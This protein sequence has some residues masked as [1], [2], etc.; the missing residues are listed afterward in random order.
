MCLSKFL[1]GLYNYGIISILLQCFQAVSP[2]PLATSLR[3]ENDSRD[4]AQPPMAHQ[5]R[6]ISPSIVI[7]NEP[8]SQELRRSESSPQVIPIMLFK[9]L[10]I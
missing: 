9:H 8:P 2:M 1:D 4:I 10:C 7:V 5:Q 6:P 3:T